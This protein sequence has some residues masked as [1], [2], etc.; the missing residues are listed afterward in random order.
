MIKRDKLN[1]EDLNREQLE[2]VTAEDGPTLVIAGAGSGKTRVLVSRAAYLISERA[3][4]PYNFLAVTFTNK[5]A[6]EMKERLANLTDFNPRSMWIGT[7]HAIC[8]RILRIEKDALAFTGNFLIYDTTDS[9]S[10]MKKI[11]AASGLDDKKYS[12]QGFWR[13]SARLK[14]NLLRRRSFLL[15]PQALGRKGRPAL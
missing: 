12:P 9:R 6:N 1:F 3:L 11:I 4:P 7:F 13:Q 14:I 15:R 5:A 2:A 8:S 10:L